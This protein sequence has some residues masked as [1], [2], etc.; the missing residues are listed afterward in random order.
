MFKDRLKQLREEAN[1]TQKEL[2]EK[3]FV[4]RSA[5]CKWEM[6]AGFPSDVNI[7]AL[8]EFFNVEEEWLLDRE[9]MKDMVNKLNKNNKSNILFILGVSLPI[10]L[11]FISF[12]PLFTK[13]TC[14]SGQACLMVFIPPKSIFMTIEWGLI[15]PSIIYGYTFVF[16]IVSKI[17]YLKNNNLISF[18]NILACVVTFLISFM[19]AFILAI[20]DGFGI[21]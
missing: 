9:D 8:C 10:I 6:G 16:S 13:G 12:L 5:I 2:G 11:T 7:K 20:N 19:V 21:L 15:F 14:D 4:S 18:I 1:L 17:K 3:I